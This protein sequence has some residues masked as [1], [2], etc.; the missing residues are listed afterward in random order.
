MSALVASSI[1]ALAA[2]SQPGGDRTAIFS[3]EYRACEQRAD[4]NVDSSFCLSD[5]LERQ[6]IQMRQGL[7][8]AKRYASPEAI[9]NLDQSQSLWQQSVDIDCKSEFEMGGSAAPMR[10]LACEIGLTISRT[11]YLNIRGSW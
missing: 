11:N 10:A 7:R 5:E 1:L 2:S 6:R 3:P 4:A 9:E 8:E